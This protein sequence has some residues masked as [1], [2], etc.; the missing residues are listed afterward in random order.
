MGGKRQSGGPRIIHAYQWGL[1]SF[2]EGTDWE[3]G[4]RRLLPSSVLSH[5]VRFGTD[6]PT[7]LCGILGQEAWESKSS[8]PELGLGEHGMP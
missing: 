3:G 4:W 2:S 6:R 7:L 1:T 5:G 8:P